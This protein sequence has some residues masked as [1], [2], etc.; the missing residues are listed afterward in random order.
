MSKLL[1]VLAQCAQWREDQS[2][3][4]SGGELGRTECSVNARRRR[5]SGTT[6]LVRGEEKRCRHRMRQQTVGIVE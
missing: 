5:L 6:F 3:S 1:A 2:H 4:Q